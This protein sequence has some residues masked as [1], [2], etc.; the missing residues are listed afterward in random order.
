MKPQ[1]QVWYIHD[2]PEESEHCPVC[3]VLED[4]THEGAIIRAQE[5]YGREQIYYVLPIGE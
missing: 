4:E 3:T 5:T 2:W 1:Y